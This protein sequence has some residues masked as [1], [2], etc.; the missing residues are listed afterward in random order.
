MLPGILGTQQALE[1]IKI[2]LDIAP[3]SSNQLYIYDLLGNKIKSINLDIHPDNPL[4][5]SQSLNLENGAELTMCSA[6]HFNEISALELYTA[7]LS[8]QPVYLI[9]VRDEAENHILNFSNVLLKNTICLEKTVHIPPEN[10]IILYCSM[11]Q[12]SKKRLLEIQNIYPEH[13]I[14]SLQNGIYGYVEAGFTLG[15][16]SPYIGMHH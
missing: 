8:H 1:A 7:L 3:S 4:R 11:G 9:D 2:L 13:D 5:I 15:I 14:Y 16:N 12:R 10:M 6:P